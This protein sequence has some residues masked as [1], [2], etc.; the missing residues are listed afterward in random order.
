MA[1]GDLHKKKFVTIG[2]MVPEIS[3]WTDTH[4][5]R[6]RQT[7]RNTLLPYWGRVINYCLA[8]V[9]CRCIYS[10][11]GNLTNLKSELGGCRHVSS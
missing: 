1:A 8:N 6:D 7:N 5:Q 4:R 3:L 11:N 2:P 9:F 10:K